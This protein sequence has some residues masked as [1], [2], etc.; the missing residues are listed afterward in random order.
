MMIRFTFSS[1]IGSI[2]GY[3][4]DSLKAISTDVLARHLETKEQVRDL[5]IPD[6]VKKEVGAKMDNPAIVKR[7]D[8]IKIFSRHIC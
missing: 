4:A 3:Q 7:P 2:A 1:W 8:M 6:T 5:E